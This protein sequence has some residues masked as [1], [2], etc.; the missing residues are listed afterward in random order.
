[1]SDCGALAQQLRKQPVSVAVDATNWSLYTG[2][3]FANCRS[4]LNHMCLLVGMN[5][6]MWRC[7]NSW[8]TSW[9]EKGYIRL[10]IGNTCG[11]CN[12]VLFPIIN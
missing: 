1:M 11:I 2:G 12:F 6:N 8:G 4:S 10:K 3:I 5:D 7:Q 9:G